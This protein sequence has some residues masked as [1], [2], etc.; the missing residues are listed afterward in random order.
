MGDAPPIEDPAILE[1]SSIGERKDTHDYEDF[2]ES[3]Q[4]QKSFLDF[5]KLNEAWESVQNNLPSVL[6]W[7]D[8]EGYE[9]PI[10]DRRIHFVL[11]VA[12][13]HETFV[14]FMKNYEDIVLKTD[15]A[16]TLV[17]VLYLDGKNPMDYKNTESLLDYYRD[18]Y[19][20]KDMQVI[21]M[22]STRFSRGAALTEGTNTRR[23]EDL[24]FFIDVDM[25]FNF[26]TLRRVRT[27]TVK[28]NQV[29]FPIVFSEY[30][31]DVVNGADY[32]KF[33]DEEGDT[34]TD[35]GRAELT[36]E[37]TAGKTEGE[38]TNLKYTKRIDDDFGYFRQYGFGILSIYKCDFLQVGGFDL[39]IKGWGM[40]D[41]QLFE[42]L[43]KS[44]LTVYRIADDSLVHI[45]H[46]VD[47]DRSLDASQY[48]MCLGTKASTYGS[49]KHMTYYML[50][51]PDVMWPEE[52][53]GAS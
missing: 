43:I 49:E 20:S 32:N 2:D 13:R 12:G 30:N 8:A 38:I 37:S 17:V 9:Y 33:K 19:S 44:N 25:M 16:V 4:Q 10:Y 39:T 6:S 36:P 21:K 46:S 23:S 35:L 24:V 29:Y 42:T 22:G 26:H 48:S 53:E 40:E 7:N 11:P 28:N 51:H 31:P 45:F 41:V 34:V 3:G 5:N 1:H 15:E 52:E 14:R 18:Q 50:N 27:N 47:C